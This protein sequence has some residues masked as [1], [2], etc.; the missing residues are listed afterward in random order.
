MCFIFLLLQKA[1]VIFSNNILLHYVFQKVIYNFNI[2]FSLMIKKE[3]KSVSS[4][5][6]GFGLTQYLLRGDK[7][8]Y[9][10]PVNH[11]I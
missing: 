3:A 2:S 8:R 1:L 11:R 4:P 10:N 7:F 6:A 9:I 5:L